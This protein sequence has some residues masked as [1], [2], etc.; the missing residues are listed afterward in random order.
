MSYLCLQVKF[1]TVSNL[2]IEFTNTCKN[3]RACV[4]FHLGRH[5]LPKYLVIIIQNE[6]G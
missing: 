1:L 2:M 4:A 6:K 3:I 5:Y